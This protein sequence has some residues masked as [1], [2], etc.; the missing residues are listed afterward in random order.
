MAQFEY[1]TLLV[2]EGIV[3]III[4]TMK[5]VKRC[6]IKFGISQPDVFQSHATLQKK[7]FKQIDNVWIM[8][9]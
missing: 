8:L 6:W 3:N 7:L 9:D 2:K 1:P 5:K 4:L